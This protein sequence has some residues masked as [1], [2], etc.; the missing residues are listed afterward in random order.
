MDIVSREPKASIGM[1]VLFVW[2]KVKNLF[3]IRQNDT[4]S[5]FSLQIDGDDT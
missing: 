3:V 1:I 2:I 4:N 5:I